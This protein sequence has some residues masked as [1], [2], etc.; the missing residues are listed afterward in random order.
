VPRGFPAGPAPVALSEAERAVY[1][2]LVAYRMSGSTAYNV[3]M[4]ARPQAV[5]Y[6]VTDS[7]AG[8][9]AWMLV[10]PGFDQWS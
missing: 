6:G 1:D 9:A 10:H 8:H 2:A 7:P 3:M 4:T 5:G